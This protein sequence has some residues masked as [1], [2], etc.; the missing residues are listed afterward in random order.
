MSIKYTLF[1]LGTIVLLTAL[2]VTFVNVSAEEGNEES[3]ENNSILNEDEE[4]V[5]TSEFTEET[6]SEKSSIPYINRYGMIVVSN[7]TTIDQ[8]EISKAVSFYQH[9]ITKGWYQSNLEFLG[10]DQISVATGIAN[11]TNVENAFK[12]IINNQLGDKEV[13]I[14]IA[15]HLWD[16]YSDVILELTDGNITSSVINDWLNNMTYSKLTF[17]MNGE[18]SGLAGPEFSNPSRNIICSMGSNDEFSPDQF[19]ITRGLINPKA[20]TNK[21]GEVSFV[22]AYYSEKNY[23]RRISNQIPELW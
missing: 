15:D 14:Y 2:T 6:E 1:L 7:L 12:D 20:D 9:L 11:V 3:K 21:D 18:H 16:G 22:E 5:T 23:L 19:N 10:P 13:M 4:N 17:I 8:N